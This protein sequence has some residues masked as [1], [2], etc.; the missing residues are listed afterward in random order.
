MLIKNF[1][2]F[3]DVKI[4]NF[5]KKKHTAGIARIELKSS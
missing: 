1:S 5:I 3:L 4:R 2:D